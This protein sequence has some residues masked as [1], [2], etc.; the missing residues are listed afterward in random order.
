MRIKHSVFAYH[1][2]V[3][4]YSKARLER[5]DGQYILSLQWGINGLCVCTY[6]RSLKSLKHFVE[7]LPDGRARRVFLFNHFLFVGGK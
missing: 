4:T 7:S 6:F 5:Y 2:L 1:V 3:D